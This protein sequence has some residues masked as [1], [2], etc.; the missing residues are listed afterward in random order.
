MAYNKLWVALIMAA[1][2]YFRNVY[3]VDLGIDEAAA[4]G[5]VGLLTAILVYAVPNKAA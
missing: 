1:A 3:N 4:N 5:L 2:E